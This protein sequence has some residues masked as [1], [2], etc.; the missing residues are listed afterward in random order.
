MVDPLSQRL[1]S[2]I[3]N[4]VFFENVTF[5]SE[6]HWQVKEFKNLLFHFIKEE[7]KIALTECDDLD[8]NRHN[9]EDDNVDDAFEPYPEDR[10]IGIKIQNLK[11]IFKT[12]A[13]KNLQCTFHLVMVWTHCSD[14]SYTVSRNFRILNWTCV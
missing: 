4:I 5:S 3:L 7:D 12:E 14:F 2:S 9:A 6:I 1:K 13:G 11:K 8:N 10:R